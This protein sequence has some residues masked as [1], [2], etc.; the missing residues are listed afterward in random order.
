VV[1]LATAPDHALTV[2]EFNTDDYGRKALAWYPG[3]F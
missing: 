2:D 1:G 3:G